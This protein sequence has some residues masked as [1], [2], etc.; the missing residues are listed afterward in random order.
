MYKLSHLSIIKGEPSVQNKKPN[1]KLS[2]DVVEKYVDSLVDVLLR[3]HVHTVRNSEN[4]AS[5]ASDSVYLQSIW[6][7]IILNGGT[8]AKKRK[9]KKFILFQTLTSQGNVTYFAE[10]KVEG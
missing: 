7:L 9:K 2:L 8:L 6:I 5:V 10:W 4:N 1:K 3:S